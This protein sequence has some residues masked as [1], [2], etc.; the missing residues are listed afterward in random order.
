MLAASP[1]LA[2]VLSIGDD[3]SVTLYNG[4]MVYSDQG[5]APVAAPTRPTNQP[6]LPH[7]VDIIAKAASHYSLSP[8]LVE[9][10]AWQESRFRVGAISPK[11]AVGLM[12]LMPGTARALGV[13][14]HDVSQN[15]HGGAAYLGQMLSRYGGNVE[16]ALAAYNAGPGA[17]D[18]Y[19]AVPPYRETQA[20]VAA[21]MGR[22]SQ[23][24]AR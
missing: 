10:V 9:A 20:Y 8:D 12:Q 7:I 19:G 13:D 4:P 22:L 21:I 2:D 1:A 15:V 17:V 5:V 24:A 6:V 14:P 23:K 11:G 16:L 18:R 3:G